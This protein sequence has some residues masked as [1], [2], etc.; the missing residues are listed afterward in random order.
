MGLKKIYIDHKARID[1]AV[2]MLAVIGLVGYINNF[3]LVW[4]LLGGLYL[5]AFYE[6]N[7][8]FGVKDNSLYTYAVLLWIVAVFY[9]YGD[10]L[11]VI[12]MVVGASLVAYKPTMHWKSFLPF[13]YP[14]AGM[15]FMLTLYKD[16]NMIAMVWLIA[17]VAGADIGAYV[18][19]KSF[20]KTKFSETSPNKTME[21]VV[22][23]IAAAT[24]IGFWFG[25][26]IVDVEKALVI[27]LVVGVSSVFG[28][29]FESYLKR[30]A[31]VKDSGDI[32]PGH[33]GVLDRMDGYLFGAIVMVILL[34]G[35][36]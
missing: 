26:R 31:G 25:T 8:L 10:D 24:L 17:V 14:T 35:L 18:F 3:F 13:I 34:R 7:Q 15:L 12:A 2:M 29:L 9:P 11:F 33:G 1:T 20:G 16:Y 28:D 4:L 30:Q 6:A 32:F 19:G 27:S 21:G 36:V 5:V 23:G 22:G